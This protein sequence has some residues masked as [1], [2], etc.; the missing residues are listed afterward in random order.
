M[1]E[2]VECAV[3]CVSLCVMRIRKFTLKIFHCETFSEFLAVSKR[4]LQFYMDNL[5]FL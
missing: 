5:P 2:P 3:F 4:F 1:N